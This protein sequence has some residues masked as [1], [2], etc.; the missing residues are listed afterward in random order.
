MGKLFRV[1]HICLD[2]AQ[3]NQAMS[4]DNSIVNHA[5]DYCKTPARVTK[6]Q[7]LNALHQSLMQLEAAKAGR[8]ENLDHAPA[9]AAAKLC[10]E[11]AGHIGFTK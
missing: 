10:L 6:K 3:A 4:Q 2:G 5:F 11:S 9:I 8:L 7:L 1:T